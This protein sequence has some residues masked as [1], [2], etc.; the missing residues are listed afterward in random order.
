MSKIY[1][2]SN[3]EIKAKE[4]LSPIQMACPD[5]LWQELNFRLNEH[6]TVSE[7]RWKNSLHTPKTL[8]FVIAAVGILSLLGLKFL[9]QIN[10][11]SYAKSA[12]VVIQKPQKPAVVK[13]EPPTAPKPDVAVVN[14]DSITKA[15]S[16]KD[17][18]QKQAE[19]MQ[20]AN[21]RA[22]YYARRDS[23]RRIMKLS[24]HGKDSTAHLNKMGSDST[25]KVIARMMPVHHHDSTASVVKDSVN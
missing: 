9:P 11:L 4:L 19:Q 3:I 5:N 10:N 12:T 21:A 1:N 17:S 15:N 18:I 6:H 22:A 23:L 20:L 13:T 16:A 14:T 2:K 8:V 25:A 24:N 7:K